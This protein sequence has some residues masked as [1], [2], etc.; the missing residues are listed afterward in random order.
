MSFSMSSLLQK[1]TGE[2]FRTMKLPDVD[3]LCLSFKDASSGY[4]PLLGK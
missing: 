4:V 1:S 3:A 2:R